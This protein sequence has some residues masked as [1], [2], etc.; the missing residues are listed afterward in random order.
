MTTRRR[1]EPLRYQIKSELLALFSQRNYRPGDKIPSESSLMDDLQV[2]R[3]TLREG[4]QLLEEEHILRTK[5]GTGRFLIT[6]PVDYK[7]D[8]THLQSAS[9]MLADYGLHPNSRLVTMNEIPADAQIAARLNILPEDLVLNLERVWYAENIPVICS[10]DFVPKY[11]LTMECN[12][13]RLN[14]SLTKF[15]SEECGIHLDHARSTIKAIVSDSF[16][17][18][19][20]LSNSRVPWILLE[21]VNYDQDGRAVIYSKDYHHS[22]YITFNVSR[23]RN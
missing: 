7:F 11:C 1:P 2:S 18:R 23:Y 3:S 5:H 4:L 22:E 14:G 9:E 21:Q 6:Q 16:L 19:V 20:G 10:V 12:P 15:L 8:I 17:M 13:V